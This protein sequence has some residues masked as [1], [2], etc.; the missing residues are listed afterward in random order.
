VDGLGKL[1]TMLGIPGA[2]LI[3]DIPGFTGQRI[4]KVQEAMRSQAARATVANLSAAR[5]GV[6]GAVPS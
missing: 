4:E 5:P 6:S 2:E 1:A 3:Q